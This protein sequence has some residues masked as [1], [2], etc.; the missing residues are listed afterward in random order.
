MHVPGLTLMSIRTICLDTIGVNGQRVVSDSKPF[1]ASNIMLAL[2]NFSIVKLFYF[3]AIQ[4][5]QVVVVLALI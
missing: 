2:F 4:A 3:A 1:L 5:D